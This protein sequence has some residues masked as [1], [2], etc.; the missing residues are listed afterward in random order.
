VTRHATL[1]EM[2]AAS[3]PLKRRGNAHWGSCPF[4]APDKT[5]SFKV[6]T[7]RGK[8][9]FKCFGCGAAGDAIDWIRLTRNISY[10]EAVA[11]LG[12]ESPKPDPKLIAARARQYG[13]Y[14]AIQ[15]YRDRNPD[16]ACP[17]YLLDVSDSPP[18]T[19]PKPPD[20]L[21]SREEEDQIIAGW[22]AERVTQP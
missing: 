22:L 13:R 11:I 3:V 19:P 9:R 7:W 8:E 18:I 15:T 17:D 6:E 16:C 10:R 5:G 20:R 2:V 21:F 12:T 1:L 14:L 4:H